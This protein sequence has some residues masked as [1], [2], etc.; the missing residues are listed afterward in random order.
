MQHRPARPASRHASRFASWNAVAEMP[1]PGRHRRHRFLPEDSR[2][3][4]TLH[5]Q[6]ASPSPR[7]APPDCA[8]T[9]MRLSRES[10][11]E[12][13]SSNADSTP[14]RSGKSGVALKRLPPHSTTQSACQRPVKIEHAGG[15]LIALHMRPGQRMLFGRARTTP[16]DRGSSYGAGTDSLIVEKKGPGSPTL[17]RGTPSALNHCLSQRWVPGPIFG[18]SFSEGPPVF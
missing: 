9:A 17:A 6:K 14:P 4:A 8:V 5:T 10:F 11:R 7:Q 12:P 3:Q 13:R 16:E 2:H 1:G 15:C 18:F